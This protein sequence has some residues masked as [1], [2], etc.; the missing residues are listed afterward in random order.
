[1]LFRDLLNGELESKSGEFKSFAA[2]WETARLH[3]AGVLRELSRMEGAQV[4]RKFDGVPGI[5]ALPSKEFDELKALIISFPEKWENHQQARN[6][7]MTVLRDR[8]TFAADGSQMAPDKNVSLPVAMVQV[9][10]FEN[11]H[12][13]EGSYEK[14][15]RQVLISPR[16]L[17]RS[18][19]DDA[20]DNPETPIGFRRFREEVSEIIRFIESKKGWKEAGKKMPLAF[21]D[22]TLLIGKSV[23]TDTDEQRKKHVIMLGLI[24]ASEENRV[25]VVG[26][27]DTSKARDLV[28]LLDN[29]NNGGSDELPLPLYDSHILRAGNDGSGIALQNWGDRTIFY[30]CH[31][32]NL[33][34]FYGRV[35]FVYLQTTAAGYPARL[36]IPAWVPE[37]GLL[38]ELIDTVR[39]ECVVG[40][41]YPYPLEAA[42][43]TAVIGM[44]ERD[45]LLRAL[46][47][48]A[49]EENIP[50]SVSRKPVSKGRRR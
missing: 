21:F 40:L 47:K 9:G 2:D 6:W 7:A 25:P 34:E 4:R 5:G 50:F 1:M 45:F 8:T 26:Y 15:A 27:I 33:K 36:D 29:V 32:I 43:A 30:H 24:R 49:K 44:S 39:A 20:Y 28:R 38:D 14:G 11:H 46:Q 37:A 16:E 10:W 48:F 35:G 31:R 3:Y 42:D 23:P 13:G 17:F 41:G 18:D 19:T 22:G 12:T